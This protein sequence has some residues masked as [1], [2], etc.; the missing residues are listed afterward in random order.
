MEI[1]KRSMKKIPDIYFV[2]GENDFLLEP[3]RKLHN[4]MEVQGVKHY[5][6]EGEGA[7]DWMYW[8]KHLE[9]SIRWAVE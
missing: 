5:Y 4:Y 9:P 2:C 6:E 8:K 3:N 1:L 7:H